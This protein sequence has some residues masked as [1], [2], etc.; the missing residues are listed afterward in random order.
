MTSTRV[1]ALPAQIVRARPRAAGLAALRSWRSVVGLSAILGGTV[2][3]IGCL[4]PWA[5]AFAG[6]VGYAGIG[7]LNGRLLAAAGGVTVVAGS[8]HLIC[9]STWS[10]WLA[11]LTGF[12]GL[13]FAGLLL[14]RL[15]GTLRSLG[16]NDMV[17]LRGGPG[18][19]VAAAGALIAFSTLFMPESA[20]RS[21][22]AVPSEGTGLLTW[23]A[24]SKSAGARRKLQIA[25]G[26]IWVLD[27]A[28]QFQ[29]FMFGRG[30]A[31]QIIEPAAM[32]SPPVIA[33]SVTS[34]AKLMLAHPALFNAAFATIQLAIGLGLLW[35][36]SARAALAGTIVWG[37]GVWWLGE[38]LGGLL[39]GMANPLTG[40]PGAALI[41]VLVAMLAWPRAAASGRVTG[42]ESLADRSP[43]GRPW[44]RALWVVLWGGLAA[45]TFQPP[46]QVSAAGLLGSNGPV[47]VLIL[48]V[49][50]AV[51]A[52]GILVPT[53]T[54]PVLA[55]AAVTAVAIWVVGE[56]FGGLLTGTATDPNTGPLLL[57]LIAAFWPRRLPEHEV[58]GAELAGPAAEVERETRPERQ[59][60]ALAVQVPARAAGAPDRLR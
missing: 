57:L 36:R 13:G 3:I 58:R 40:A 51:I 16:S 50:F 48:G 6:L 5:E 17:I 24:D 60:A 54:R 32:G 38:A 46:V 52:V 8:W 55:L 45:L 12:A 42:R 2:L 44:A 25:L 4:L 27:A 33:N 10:R 11:G 20:Q 28:L 21:V 35:R 31:T 14:L 39:S 15:A 43:V 22:R 23:A 53:A 59:V 41:Y 49:I 30:F 9:G 34:A 37:L 47:P 19:W 7:G 1:P 29:P 18:L 56:H 26:L